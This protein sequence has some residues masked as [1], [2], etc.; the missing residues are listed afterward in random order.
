M[1][2]IK[3][4]QQ[5]AEAIEA[6]LHEVNGTAT[7]HAYTSFDDVFNQAFFAE[8]ALSALLPVKDYPG[9]RW[10]KTSGH[11]V[12]RSYRGQRIATGIMLERRSSAWY[13]VRVVSVKLFQQG[14]G[15]GR[16]FLTK[17]Q[18]EKAKERFAKQYNVIKESV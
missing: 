6:A 4:Q 11:S 14:G 5:N 15:P 2:P 9:A 8:Q 7:A 13:L 12:A 16:L 1:K 10:A 3:I 17:E 18:D